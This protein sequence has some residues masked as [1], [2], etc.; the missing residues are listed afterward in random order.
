[1]EAHGRSG[2]LA[3]DTELLMAGAV[4]TELSPHMKGE[5]T[6]MTQHRSSNLDH[7]MMQGASG[8]TMMLPPR[9]TGE[10]SRIQV[11]V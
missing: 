5:I 10:L 1:M 6:K 3:L 4:K 9:D 2:G 11:Q 7:F 8:R